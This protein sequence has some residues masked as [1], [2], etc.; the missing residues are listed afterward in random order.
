MQKTALTKEQSDALGE[1]S[2]IF[3]GNAATTLSMIINHRVDIT[4][5]QVVT[6]DRSS[7]LDDYHDICTFVQINYIKGLTGSNVFVLKDEDVLVLTDLM[8]GGSGVHPAGPIHEMHMSAASEA[9]NQMM[10]TNATSMAS[11]LNTPV[12]ISAPEVS[13]IDVEGVKKFEK[14]FASYHEKFVRIR[15][16][17]DVE[18]LLH[19]NMVQLFPVQFAIDLYRR[20]TR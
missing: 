14:M 19:S 9:M 3:M 7:A 20:F 13:R 8:M 11:M 18:H 2:N 6:I 12:D 4:A 15:F 17:M 5:P 1:I 16:Q 10:G